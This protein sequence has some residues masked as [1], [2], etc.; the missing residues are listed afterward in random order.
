MPILGT[1]EE[2]G[3]CRGH[4]D[5]EEIWLRDASAERFRIKPMSI[6]GCREEIL[7]YPF[8]GAGKHKAGKE[9]SAGD[10]LA[11]VRE[12]PLCDPMIS[13]VEVKG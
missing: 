3:V 4:G 12:V 11:R 1:V 6:R 7:A 5:E 10:W 2:Y 8:A 9:A 13:G